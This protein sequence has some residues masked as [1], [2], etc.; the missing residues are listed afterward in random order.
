MHNKI[1]DSW[2]YQRLASN[3]QKPF[4][5]QGGNVFAYE[6]LLLEIKR[7]DDRVGDSISPGA[8]VA[9]LGDYTLTAVATLLWLYFNRNIAVPI[10]SYST[11]EIADRISEG[12]CE[13]VINCECTGGDVLSIN[14][15]D[16]KI[17]THQ[18][19]EKLRS[20]GHA[21][22]VLF[23]SG[24]A[25]KPKAMIHDLTR[26]IDTYADKK[27]RNLAILIFLMFDHI[28]GIN[29]LFTSLASG[30]F[31]V[32]PTNRDA[33]EV[34]ALIERYKVSILPASPTFLNLLLISD[35]HRRHDLT[36]LKIITYGTEPMHESLLARLREEF[37]RV[38]FLQ[39]FGTSETGISR[40]ESKSSDSLFMKLDD[41]DIEH[42]VVDGELWLRSKTQ[43]LGYLN[44]SMERFTSDG[45]FRTGD[46]VETD[47]AG[48]LRIVG[49]TSEMIN[50]GGEK[51]APSE[52]ESVLLEVKG[53]I[54][55]VVYGLA[56]PIT[57]Q[58]VAAKV[59][60]QS[61]VDKA[62]LKNAIRQHCS[63]RLQ[64]Y[65][66]PVKIEFVHDTLFSERFKKK[67]S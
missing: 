7:I 2:L 3:G 25:G 4:L 65:K 30:S 41:P 40:S 50:V 55:C 38:R 15:I 13:Y 66:V 44:S 51:V 63:K 36:S 27:S 35:A 43:I 14:K 49:R 12:F 5:A 59:V 57:G 53:I 20:D 39:T 24:S 31:I 56:S 21:G 62:M 67:R 23:S 61:D 17:G 48:Y 19:L 6:D 54:D 64:R 8:C 33:I 1:S 18:L 10:A 58:I 26:L 42:K 28:G 47:D 45:W 22:L 16:N 46:K 34:A 60:A 11:N 32:A 37:P 52:V 29:T 9:F